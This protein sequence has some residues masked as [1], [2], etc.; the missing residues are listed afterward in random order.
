M[1]KSATWAIWE[2]R[3]APK[4]SK[5]NFAIL[6]PQNTKKRRTHMPKRESDFLQL[7]YFLKKLK[8]FHFFAEQSAKGNYRLRCAPF[9]PKRSKSL[10]WRRW[11]SFRSK[12][13]QAALF[14]TCPTFL[15]VLGAPKR[16][17][18]LKTRFGATFARW[19][20]KI[21]RVAGAV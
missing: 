2:R 17:W 7:F 4:C 8:T 16:V 14:H 11:S 21:V 15:G 20:P 1:S 6:T 10:K 19:D 3:S 12:M 9:R 5:R 13:T 18:A